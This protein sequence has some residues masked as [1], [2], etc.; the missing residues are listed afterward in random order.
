M[1]YSVRAALFV[2]IGLMAGDL[3]AQGLTLS[4]R[5]TDSKTGE[6]LAGVSVAIPT[7]N[8]GA[9]TDVDGRYSFQLA[10]GNY[11]VVA[12]YVGYK[13]ATQ[14]IQIAASNL[15]LDFSL[16]ADVIGLDQVVVVGYGE[17]SRRSITGSISSVRGDDVNNGCWSSG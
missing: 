12:T 6:A 13:R 11:Q 2:L 1:R 17:V 14:N 3:F 5:V 10:A 15:V 9:F 4:G 7:M 16:E 8:R